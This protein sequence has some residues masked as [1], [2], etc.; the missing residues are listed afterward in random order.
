MT[1]HEH[2]ASRLV[3]PPAT[4]PSSPVPAIVQAARPRQWVKSLL[5]LSVP[6][7]AGRL[8]EPQVAV[9]A[10]VAFVCFC[11]VS[12]AVYLLNDVRDV[13]E[14]RRHP[15]KRLRPV[16][17]GRLRPASAV[18]AGGVLAVAGVTLAFWWTMTLGLVLACYLAVQVAY[19]F[20]LKGQAVLDLGVV[21]SGFVLRAVAGGAATD[22]DMSSTLML[23]ALFGSLFMV[24]GK[25]YS[26][27]LQA[28]GDGRTRASLRHYSASY[29]RFV[30]TLAATLTILT[31]VLWAFAHATSEPGGISWNVISVVPFTLGMMR[32]AFRVDHGRAGAPEDVVLGDRPLQLVGLAW[33]ATVLPG[34]MA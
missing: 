5:V 1:T 13:E 3:P 32:Y 2:R 19:T 26:E 34:L 12:S 20:G 14:D 28:S 25:R 24:A 8:L 18:T 11:A 4:R 29:L 21:A 9:G 22:I 17:A 16:A 10:L 23:V 27:I 15:T 31:Y 33:L 7:A 6:V 30:W